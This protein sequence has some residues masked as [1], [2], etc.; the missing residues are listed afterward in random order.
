MESEIE[1]KAKKVQGKTLE[2]ETIF[3]LFTWIWQGKVKKNIEEFS[4]LNKKSIVVQGSAAVR[5]KGKWRVPL[6]DS[7]LNWFYRT[8][9]YKCREL[10]AER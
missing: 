3:W 6:E 5:C 1:V 4:Y 7:G 8:K 9:V 2:H 10:G